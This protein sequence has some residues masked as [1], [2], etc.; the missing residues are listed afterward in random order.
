MNKIS[1]FPDKQEVIVETVF[2][3]KVLGTIHTGVSRVSGNMYAYVMPINES[4][5]G[6]AITQN[7]I[8]TISAA[9]SIP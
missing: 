8:L 4:H 1:A 3:K 7:E 9:P 2:N 5:P 6:A